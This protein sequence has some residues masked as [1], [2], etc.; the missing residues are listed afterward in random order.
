MKSAEIYTN[1]YKEQT[2]SQVFYDITLSDSI[3][4]QISGKRK[5]TTV[6]QF[7]EDTYI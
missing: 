6:N 5:L 1:V 4:C 7:L 2:V 3:T